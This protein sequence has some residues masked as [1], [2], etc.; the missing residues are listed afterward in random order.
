MGLSRFKSNLQF[1]TLGGPSRRGP[2]AWI[3]SV[4]SEAQNQH[5]RRGQSC[6]T[7]LETN[8]CVDSLATTETSCIS[9]SRPTAPSAEVA[10][11]PGF[12]A[13]F[14]ASAPTCAAAAGPLAPRPAMA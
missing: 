10:L 9:P 14:I 13:Q 4:D 11:L 3:T 6:N 8:T 1:G 12:N 2:C 5:P 7:T